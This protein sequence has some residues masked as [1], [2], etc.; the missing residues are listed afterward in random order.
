MDLVKL[1]DV[2]SPK[3][4]KDTLNK[5]LGMCNLNIEDGT[6]KNSIQTKESFAT[7]EFAIALGKGN[8]AEG[9]KTISLG[10]SNIVGAYVRVSP[11]PSWED[12]STGDYYIMHGSQWLPT[13]A[14]QLTEANYENVAAVY[15]KNSNSPTLSNSSCAL[16]RMNR[17]FANAAGAFGVDNTVDLH[18]GSAFVFGQKNY[19][20]SYYSLF[21][22]RYNIDEAV[23]TYYNYVFGAYNKVGA[24]NF[25]Y[26]FGDHLVANTGNQIIFGQYNKNNPNNVLEIGGGSNEDHC[27]NIFEIDRQGIVTC[28]ALSDGV[29][30]KTITEILAGGGNAAVITTTVDSAFFETLY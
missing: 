29:S 5:Y 26:L 21:A 6:G 20:N 8:R 4:L 23:A 1:L 2:S 16:G 25:K 24:G 28:S 10:H 13:T 15:Q 3:R 18:G 9:A 12:A 27:L 17:V 7:G 19:L 14:E 22:G 30:T 11:K